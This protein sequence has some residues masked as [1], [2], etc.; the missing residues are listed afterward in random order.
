MLTEKVGGKI[1]LGLRMVFPVVIMRFMIF[2]VLVLM[3]AG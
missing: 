2:P 1:V 3:S